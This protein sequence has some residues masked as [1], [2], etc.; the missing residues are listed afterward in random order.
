L[1]DQRCWPPLNVVTESLAFPLVPRFQSELRAGAATCLGVG[2]LFVLLLFVLINAGLAAGTDEQ[3]VAINESGVG[4]VTGDR[5]EDAG[6]SRGIIHA[7]IVAGQ[8]AVGGEGVPAK[9][10]LAHPPLAPDTPT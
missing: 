6:P 8:Q 2:I 10:T 7:K 4:Q 5:V 3:V 1:V 9:D